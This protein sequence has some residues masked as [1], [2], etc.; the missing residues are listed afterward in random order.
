MIRLSKIGGYFI[1]FTGP[2]E[3]MI[4]ANELKHLGVTE[5]PDLSA[6]P[7]KKEEY[8]HLINNKA[9]FNP[10]TGRTYLSVL[11]IELRSGSAFKRGYIPEGYKAKGELRGFPDDVINA[12]LSE[13]RK[14]GNPMDLYVFEDSTNYS[15]LDG[16][17]DWC[18]ASSPIGDSAD[19][20][21]DIIEQ[22]EFH[23]IESYL[24]KFPINVG[25]DDDV[26]ERKRPSLLRKTNRIKL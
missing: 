25:W 14:Q 5:M 12:M 26:P 3:A 23:L 15:E 18:D 24:E 20:W 13:Q 7:S 4:I 11:D 10:P 21:F 8:I 17:F 22:K 16:G 6:V 2:I 9:Y 19:Y 1:K